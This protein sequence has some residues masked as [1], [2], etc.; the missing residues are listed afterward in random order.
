MLVE[1]FRALFPC[2]A[3]AAVV[4]ATARRMGLDVEE[5]P[6]GAAGVLVIASG[7]HPAPATGETL[8]ALASAEA[9]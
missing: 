1:V 3:S 5:R 6:A 9:A 2:R 7:L 4:A 8:A